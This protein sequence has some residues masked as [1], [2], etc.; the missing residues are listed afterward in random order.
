MFDSNS[1]DDRQL[2]LR[3]LSC[4]RSKALLNKFLRST[5][6]S[7]DGNSYKYKNM[8]EKIKIF[9]HVLKSGEKG[10]NLVIEFVTIHNADMKK[11]FGSFYLDDLI[12]NIASH[13]KNDNQAADVS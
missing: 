1:R 4:T 6:N 8:F 9:E 5:L 12:S 7:L 2:F 3:F 10:V 11:E 13:I